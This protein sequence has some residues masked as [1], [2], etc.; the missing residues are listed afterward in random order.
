[1]N[2]IGLAKDCFLFFYSCHLYHSICIIYW[3][4]HIVHVIIVSFSLILFCNYVQLYKYMYKFIQVDLFERKHCPRT[5]IKQ[6]VFLCHHSTQ[7]MYIIIM[8]GCYGH[9]LMFLGQWWEYKWQCLSYNTSHTAAF[10]R[11]Q[12]T[13]GL[14]TAT[15]TSNTKLSPTGNIF[16]VFVS[17][18]R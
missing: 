17:H 8:Y 4:I 2:L 13:C 18:G 3:S 12:M 6:N 7:N 11:H 5:L 1:M 15:T 10:V 16:T 14:F 9:Q